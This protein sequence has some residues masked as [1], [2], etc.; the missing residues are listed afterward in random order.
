MRRGEKEG[1]RRGERK[2]AGGERE[3]EAGIQKVEAA[4]V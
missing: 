2:K 1:S 3:D 4:C